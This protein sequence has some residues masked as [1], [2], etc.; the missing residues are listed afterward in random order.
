MKLSALSAV[1]PIDGRY[2][3]KTELLRE[4]FSEYGLIKRR[5]LVEIRWLQCLAAHEGVPEVP[6]LS[7]AATRALNNIADKFSEVD[8]R[9]I[10]DIEATTNHDVKAVEYFIKERFD[11]NRELKA[12]AEFV[13][14]ACTSE[15]INNLSHAL[16]LR[17]GLRD[18]L[19]PAMNEI[20]DQ[21]ASLTIPTICALNGNVFGAGVELALSCDFR[22]GVEG[23]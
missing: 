17:D 11:G 21:L 16:M 7:K 19:L 15:D 23:S 8:A 6:S 3:S 18:V 14:F 22:L 4:V 2:G 20:A 12:I 13:H 5:V 9:R 1:S 10:K